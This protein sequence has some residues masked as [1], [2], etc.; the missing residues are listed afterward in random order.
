[1]EFVH[2]TNHTY[3]TKRWNNFYRVTSDSGKKYIVSNLNQKS[4]SGAFVMSDWACN[5]LGWINYH[6]DCKHI[7][8]LKQAINFTPAAVRDVQ[9]ADSKARKSIVGAVKTT[10]GL[11]STFDVDLSQD[12]KPAAMRSIAKQLLSEFD[13]ID[14]GD[15]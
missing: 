4:Q 1:M 13:A 9:L 11:V 6:K 10:N 5:C 8:A 7:R 3:R 2:L 15:E 12:E 14:L